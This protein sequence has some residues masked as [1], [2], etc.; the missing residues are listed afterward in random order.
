MNIDIHCHLRALRTK[1]EWDKFVTQSALRDG[2]SEESIRERLSDWSDVTGDL[3][4]K[5]MDDAGIDK[6][7][8]LPIDL[9]LKWGETA[10]LSV[11]GKIICLEE[12][13]KI[14]AEAV[15]RHPDRLIMFGGIDPRRHGALQFVER[16]M[17]EWNIKGLKLHPAM[18][19]FDPSDKMCYRLYTKCEEWGLPILFHSGPQMAPHYDKYCH[20]LCFSD[21]SSDFPN[22][23][24]ILGHACGAYWPGA[25]AMAANKANVFLDICWWQPRFLRRPLENF[26][27]PLRSMLDMCGSSKVMFGSDW[28]AYR[29][30]R[31]S[32]HALFVKAFTEISDEVKAA[33]IEFK[34][35]EI[36]RIMGGNAVKLLGIKE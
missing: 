15:N 12:L 5:D 31:R 13:H 25:A 22:L 6:S 19:G 9:A 27:R 34:D 24:I 20:P 4:V 8:L 26:Y 16:A 11:E 36:R 18:G 7:V 1:G 2:L 35:E 17:K 21:V 14:Y 3:I 29:V 10:E 28:P 23:K 33:G 30:G 32:T